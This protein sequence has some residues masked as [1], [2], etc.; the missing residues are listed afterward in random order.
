VTLGQG[1]FGSAQVPG[2][3]GKC[4]ARFPVYSRPSPM[5]TTINRTTHNSTDDTDVV[6]SPRA[7]RWTV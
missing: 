3:A 2:T 4:G 6:T 1:L 7:V 5:L